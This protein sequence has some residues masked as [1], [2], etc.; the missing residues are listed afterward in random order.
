M[1]S[2][3]DSRI[4]VGVDGSDASIDAL[5]RAATFAAAF[6]APLEAIMT[7]EYPVSFDGGYYLLDDWSPENDAKQV[8]DSVIERALGDTVPADFVG[9][10]LQ[11]P[12]ARVLIEQS[13]HAAMLVVGSRGHGG[14]VGLLLGSVSAACAAH[15][16]C[17]VLIVHD[18][19]IEKA[20]A[21]SER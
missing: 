16:H 18:P 2:T 3:H 1:T 10:T 19:G 15:A 9:T 20:T 13:E 7:W 8:L 4:L 6:D 21:K 5:R 11:G 14:F 12:P 17:P